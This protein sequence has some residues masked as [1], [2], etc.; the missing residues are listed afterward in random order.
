MDQTRRETGW[1]HGR[2]SASFSRRQ[3][4]A[5]GVGVGGILAAL[6]AAF[7]TAAATPRGTTGAEG[8]ATTEVRS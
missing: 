2:E 3:R 1:S 8:V 5:L 7:V 6:L 4:L